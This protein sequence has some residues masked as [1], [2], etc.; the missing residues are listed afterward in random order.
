M[1]VKFIHIEMHP[2]EFELKIL[3]LSLVQCKT[4][5]GS[6]VWTFYVQ[7]ADSLRASCDFK[8][9]AE[10]HTLSTSKFRE[11]RKALITSIYHGWVIRG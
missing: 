11:Q 5:T 1:R 4:H 10:A 3:S 9:R 7:V 6:F 8:Q 2:K